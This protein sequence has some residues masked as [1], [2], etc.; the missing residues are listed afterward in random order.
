MSNGLVLLVDDEQNNL[1]ILQ[2]ALQ[3]TYE[4]QSFTDPRAALESA[5]QALPDAVIIDYR[6]PHMNGIELLQALRL[7]D[8]TVAVIMT[9]AYADDQ[10]ARSE[11]I[12]L[13]YRVLAKPY[14]PELIC[15]LTADAIRERDLRREMLR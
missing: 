3:D 5:R 2:R 6:M 1:D 7:L 9:T 4:L 15:R 13:L 11:Q 8:R 10:V 12:K 14:D